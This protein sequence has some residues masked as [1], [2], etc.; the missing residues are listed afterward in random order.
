MIEPVELSACSVTDGQS[1]P[2]LCHSFRLRARSTCRI[3]RGAGSRWDLGSRRRS[4]CPRGGGAA[5]GRDR[6]VW[7]ERWAVKTL[8][9]RPRLLPVR[10]TTVAHLVSLPRPPFVPRTRLPFERH[11]YRVIASATLLREE[12]DQDLHV[13]LRSG[14]KQM[15]SEAPNAPACT[16]NATTYRKRQMRGGAVAR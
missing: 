9:D 4:P 3:C 10:A 7:V 2:C 15:I 1:T 14:S 5:H 6:G 13:I 16:P 11:V 12:D 8:Q